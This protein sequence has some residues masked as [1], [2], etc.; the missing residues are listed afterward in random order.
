MASQ[1]PSMHSDDDG[2]DGT[3]AIVLGVVVGIIVV[4]VIIAIILLAIYKCHQRHH[5][6]DKLEVSNTK[7]SNRPGFLQMRGSLSQENRALMV[8]NTATAVTPSDRQLAANGVHQQQTPMDN[9]PPNGQ[10]INDD[11]FD[12]NDDSGP[13][14]GDE[15]MAEDVKSTETADV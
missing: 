15:D 6:H 2:S 12:R 4:G 11:N 14:A 3:I 13:E 5:R 7:N 8:D 10:P 1:S 9:S